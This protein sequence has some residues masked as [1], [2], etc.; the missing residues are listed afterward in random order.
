MMLI[1]LGFG[2]ASLR[3]QEKLPVGEGF[4]W[5]GVNY[6]AWAKDFYKCV[7]VDHV[8]DF[9][10][11]R[12]APSGIVHYGTRAVLWP[13][14]SH[15]ESFRI[16][17]ESKNLLLAFGIYNLALLVLAV[18]IWGLIA[19]NL[20]LSDRGRWFGF[21]FLFVNYATL[22]LNFY[23]PVA[24]DTSAFFLGLLMFYFFLARKALGLFAIMIIGSFTWPTLPFTAWLLLVLP[25]P[26]EPLPETGQHSTP[27]LRRFALWLSL[28]V[29]ALVAGIYAYLSRDVLRGWTRAGMVRIDFGLLYSSIAA[30]LVYL[31][32]G[33]RA[34]FLDKRLFDVRHILRAIRW[35]W[36]IAGVLVI[37][38]SRLVVHRLAG[39]V[40]SQ[41]TFRDFLIY[42]FTSALTE[43]FIFVV[44]HVVY[45]GPII[46]LLILF[47]KSFCEMIKPYGVGFRLFVAMNL[48]L[49]LCPQS[50]YQIPAVG[51]FVILLVKLL[52]KEWLPRWSFSIWLLLSLF[53][54]KVWYTFNTSP[55]NPDGTM[56]VFQTFPLQ[57]FFMNSGPWMSYS[58]YLVQGGIVA[59]TAVLILWLVFTKEAPAR[60]V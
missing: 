13:F 32:L 38:G 29:C 8:E 44:S 15:D 59:A 14:Y 53:Y 60:E 24:T 3:W 21:C 42:I 30:V 9:Y 10:V 17:H 34:V 11:Q 2:V 55:M 49:S 23:T 27:G 25:R 4:G 47:W 16:L 36:V 26:A 45:Y 54:S 33:F 12:V 5:D 6:A 18:Y 20:A 19:D 52:D 43:P 31:F 41:W 48:L 39:P 58:M 51:A 22:K 50:R 7:F 57:N 28:F 40:P 35:R 46:L 1:M 56:A 37:L